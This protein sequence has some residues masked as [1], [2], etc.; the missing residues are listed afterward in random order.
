[1]PYL[2]NVKLVKVESDKIQQDLINYEKHLVVNNYKFGV[3]YWKTGQKEED[4]FYCNKEGS[5]DYE[6][7]L[8]F[9]GEKIVLQGWSKFRGGLNVKDNFTGTHSVYTVYRNYEIMY[10]IATLIPYTELDPQQVERKR[11]LGNDVVVILF[12]DEDNKEPF[13]PNIM[14][15]HVNHIFAIVQPDKSSGTTKYRLA[16][17]SKQG[18]PPYNPLLPK[19]GIFDKSDPLLRDFLITKL[20]NGERMAMY[21]QE[22]STKMNNTRQTLL[23]NMYKTYGPNK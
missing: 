6:E 17:A 18:V 11:H 16:F 4:E 13:N 3:L 9:L 14:R 15:S 7:F 8:N 12:R 22:F 21:G 5:P 2:Q 20:I 1:L 19:D 10:H 23:S